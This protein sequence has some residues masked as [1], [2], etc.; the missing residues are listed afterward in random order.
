[1]LP[2]QY[3]KPPT[4]AGT[5]G[6]RR[7]RRREREPGAVEEGSAKL[8]WALGVSSELLTSGKA[9]SRA[10]LLGKFSRSAMPTPGPHAAGDP[11]GKGK[12]PV[13]RA[14]AAKCPNGK[15]EGKETQ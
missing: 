4:P 11:S 7:T 3:P 15:L 14:P 8:P 6:E 9:P 13:G 2:A 12:I 5:D 1:M 10:R